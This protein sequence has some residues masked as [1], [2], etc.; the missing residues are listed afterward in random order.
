MRPD[1]TALIHDLG[2][3]GQVDL[4]GPDTHDA[5]P[6]EFSAAHV[7]AVPSVVDRSGDRDGLPNVVLEAMAC[8]RPVVGTDVGAIASAVV[9]CETGYVVAA[10]D[11][12]ALAARL[13]KLAL[14]RPLM[15]AMG[16][17][18]RAA[19]LQRYEL[20][21]CTERLI[22]RFRDAYV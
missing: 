9:D 20:G 18:A 22:A 17:A 11:P 3:R 6:D 5:L 16:D 8:G 10:N 2:L 15:V 7:L 12:D 1:L 21:R 4:H 14:D 13:Q 19:I